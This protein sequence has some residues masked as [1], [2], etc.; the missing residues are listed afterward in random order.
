VVETVETVA[1]A[2]SL[3]AGLVLVVAGLLSREPLQWHLW[4]TGVV[5][6]VL[7]V[8][9]VVAVIALVQGGQIEGSV[10]VFLAYL[11]GTLLALPLAVLWVLG[12]P[13]R[14]ST[15]ALGVVC[16]VVAVLLLRLDQIW[17]GA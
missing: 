9:A 11:V 3:L 4:V 12:E 6:V 10:G 8:F 17:T 14:W 2:V 7:V 1:L 16:L 13:S 5:E 15:V